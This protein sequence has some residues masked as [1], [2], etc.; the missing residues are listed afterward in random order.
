M[1]QTDVE[2]RFK[3]NVEG[4][5]TAVQG[6]NGQLSAV[7][8]QK[9]GSSGLDKMEEGARKASHAVKETHESVTA[10][11]RATEITKDKLGE[12]TKEASRFTLGFLGVAGAFEA[13]KH[14][15]EAGAAVE[16]GRVRMQAL[17]GSAEPGN[18]ALGG[19]EKIS[20]A[21]STRIEHQGARAPSSV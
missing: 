10:F 15:F 13:V 7:A 8:S 1:P 21:T 14:A 6:I 2:V 18:E 3:A 12:F 9:V 4:L 17:V 16:T 19:I 11:G 20:D 5:R